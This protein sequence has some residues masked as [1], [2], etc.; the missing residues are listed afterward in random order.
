MIGGLTK[1]I[2]SFRDL[3]VKA[4]NDFV[5]HFEINCFAPA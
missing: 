5:A 2:L 3:V 1:L 4:A